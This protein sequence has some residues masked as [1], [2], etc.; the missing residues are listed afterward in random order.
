MALGFL[1]PD[2]RLRIVGDLSVIV[3]GAKLHTYVTGTPSTN[4]QT[5]SDSALTVPNANPVVASAFGL[6]GPIYLTPGLGYKLVLADANDVAIWTQDPILIPTSLTVP[7]TVAQGGT[8]QVTLTAHGVVLGEGVGG[9]AV[10]G[11]GTIGQALLSGGAAADPT[12]QS[13]TSVVLDKSTTEQLISNSAAAASIYSF[14]VPGGTLGTNKTLRLTLTGSYL[15]NSGV[16]DNLFVRGQLGGVTVVGALAAGTA[17]FN[18]PASANVRLIRM[19]IELN[20]NGLTNSQRAVGSIVIGNASALVTD[21]GGVTA[22]PYGFANALA[23]DS[24]V[25]QTLDVSVQLA[26][27]L[28]TI[29]FRRF[30]AVLEVLG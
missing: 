14:V 23:L 25:N 20:A 7:V 24:T 26:T 1:T 4:Q 27:A 12:F 22:L 29:Q 15:N 17:V 8:G 19:Q 18:V 3:P 21:W 9:V 2:A 11:P 13:L 16:A 30:T 5:F 6:F 28:A 10:T